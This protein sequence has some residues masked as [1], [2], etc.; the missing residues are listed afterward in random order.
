[1]ATEYQFTH[2]LFSNNAQIW[3]SIFSAS[4]LQ[5]RRI[6]EVG[7]YEG[8]SAC[9]LLDECPTL[10]E[11]ICVDPWQGMAEVEARFDD[12]ILIALKARTTPVRV[13]KVK[14]TS[15][16]AL[17]TLISQNEKFDLIYIDGSHTAPDVLA[18]LGQR[19]PSSACWRLAYPR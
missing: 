18:E 3:R 2:D 13:R 8:R 15:L 10:E 6:L 12:N 9:F 17:A 4:S 7:S 19:V 1:M 5:P 14:D 16:H 11:L